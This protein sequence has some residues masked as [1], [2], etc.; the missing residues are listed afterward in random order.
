MRKEIV[1]RRLCVGDAFEKVLCQKKWGELAYATACFV[2][3]SLDSIRGLAR[4]EKNSPVLTNHQ[5]QAEH[6]CL[7]HGSIHQSKLFETFCEHRV[8]W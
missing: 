2:E 4:R 5:G 1:L 8:L 6:A 7:N 3:I